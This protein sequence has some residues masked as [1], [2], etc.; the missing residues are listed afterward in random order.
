M[1]WTPGYIPHR[2]RSGP[3]IWAS[4][5]S[6]SAAS[7]LLYKH[8]QRLHHS[9]SCSFISTA[10]CFQPLKAVGTS[11]LTPWSLFQPFQRC[12]Q[13]RLISFELLRNSR[14][15]VRVLHPSWRDLLFH[16]CRLVSKRSAVCSAPGVLS[17][18]AY[19]SP[20]HDGSVCSDGRADAYAQLELRT[21]E[22]SL[23]ATCVGSISELS[24]F[25][26]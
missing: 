14:R 15:K 25:G 17:L 2:S 20:Y 11:S 7:Q 18:P 21:L 6:C 1:R 26:I 5:Y 16:T 4:A 12:S 13:C 8:E 24:K 10:I 23:L 9:F 22:Q 3:S 19:F